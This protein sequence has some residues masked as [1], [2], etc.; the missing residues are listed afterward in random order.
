MSIQLKINRFLFGVHYFPRQGISTGTYRKGKDSLICSQSV[1]PV[2]LVS[3][4]NN[5]GCLVCRL[6]FSLQSY[7]W[8]RTQV[9]SILQHRAQCRAEAFVSLAPRSLCIFQMRC[10][11]PLSIQFQWMIKRSGRN[12][13]CLR[14]ALALP[15]QRVRGGT[16]YLALGLLFN[17]LLGIWRQI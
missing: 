8:M 4:L 10:W 11:E 9:L 7:R 17:N 14:D 1:T 15:D 13:Y 6:V 16:S 2:T 5:W 12:L 3:P